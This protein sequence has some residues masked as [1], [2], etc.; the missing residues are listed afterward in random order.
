MKKI[1]I[2]FFLGLLTFVV[3]AC[4]SDNAEPEVVVPD[5]GSK[6]EEIEWCSPEDIAW[7]FVKPEEAEDMGLV[8]IAQDDEMFMSGILSNRRT[9]VNMRR[10]VADTIVIDLETPANIRWALLFDEEMDLKVSVTNN[11]VF[12]SYVWIYNPCMV[13]Y[14]PIIVESLSPTQIRIVRKEGDWSSQK[15]VE[16]VLERQM[17]GMVPFEYGVYATVI[18]ELSDTPADSRDTE[19]VHYISSAQADELGLVHIPFD[20]EEF[21]APIVENDRLIVELPAEGDYVTVELNSPAMLL[22]GEAMR[23]Y[24]EPIS[25]PAYR[26]EDATEWIFYPCKGYTF[27]TFSWMEDPYHVNISLEEMRTSAK[28]EIEVVLERYD[29]LY[30]PDAIGRQAAIHIVRPQE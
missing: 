27:E 3:G 4:A 10:E 11:A 20:S 18:V 7:V 24:M 12:R 29:R 15:P 17:I 28:S 5:N 2:Y 6:D 25:R 23:Y 16:V 9:T 22:Q 30:A 8:Y 14:G 13:D 21:Q 1:I 26:H 19:Y